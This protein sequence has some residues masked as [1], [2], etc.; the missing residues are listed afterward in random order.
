ML[1]KVLYSKPGP[2]QPTDIPFTSP[3]AGSP[4]LFFLSGSGWS[5]NGQEM[6]GVNVA[7]D[8]ETFTS[9]QAFTNEAKSH[10]TF[11]S[12]INLVT[13]DFGQH[14]LSLQPSSNLTSDTNDT[15]TVTLIY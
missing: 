15:F 1:S 14:K 2:L 8:G 7:L 6:V 9:M 5:P 11:V 13:L 12:E 4:V 3:V 10:V